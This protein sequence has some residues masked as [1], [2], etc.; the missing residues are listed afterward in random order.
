MV[1]VSSLHLSCQECLGFVEDFQ[2]PALF[3]TGPDEGRFASRASAHHRDL[4]EVVQV[5][6]CEGIRQRAEGPR[7]ARVLLRREAVL[8]QRRHL[9]TANPWI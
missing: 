6:L 8:L 9:R 1:R 5:R 2:P 7:R 4:R 3:T